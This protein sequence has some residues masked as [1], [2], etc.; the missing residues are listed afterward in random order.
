MQKEQAI[1][2]S[3]LLVISVPTGIDRIAQEQE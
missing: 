2:Q 1:P 3:G